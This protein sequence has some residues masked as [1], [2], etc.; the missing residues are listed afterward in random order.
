MGDLTLFLRRVV[1]LPLLPPANLGLLSLGAS[2]PVG[3]GIA[4]PVTADRNF[5]SG[6]FDPLVAATVNLPVKGPLLALA[7][8][9]ARWIWDEDANGKQSGSTVVGGLGLT[10]PLYTERV[11]VNVIGEY[12]WRGADSRDGIPVAASG[13]HWAY[14]SAGISLAPMADGPHGPRGWA[15]LSW[16]VWRNVNGTQLAEDVTIRFGITY[17]L[18]ILSHPK[19]FGDL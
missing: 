9:Y 5:V 16:P 13:G 14:L 11:A 7:N 2:V 6:T 15:R 19:P 8:V 10:A 3:T 4:N 17:G 18:D 12:L 1:R